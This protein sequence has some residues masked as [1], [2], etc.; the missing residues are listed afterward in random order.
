MIDYKEVIDDKGL[1]FAEPKLKT[2]IPEKLREEILGF[3]LLEWISSIYWEISR[4]IEQASEML[5]FS[6]PSDEKNEWL[7]VYQNKLDHQQR[8]S[9]W[10]LNHNL[11]PRPVKGQG[12]GLIQWRCRFIKDRSLRSIFYK[13]IKDGVCSNRGLHQT[14]D[15]FVATYFPSEVIRGLSD[16]AH[17]LIKTTYKEVFSSRLEEVLNPKLYRPIEMISKFVHGGF[18]SMALDEIMG[19]AI[20]LG[21]EKLSLTRNLEVEFLRLIRCNQKYQI[22]S[23][24][25]FIDGSD[26]YTVGEVKEIDTGKVCAKGKAKFFLLN[27]EVCQRIFPGIYNDPQLAYL[28]R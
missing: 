9:S 7:K 18:I 3:E 14:I 28:Y 11:Y 12:I 20:T 17:D 15:E 13:M 6:S 24:V 10:L 16:S 25:I 26:V 4:D 1:L 21:M 19:Y 8:I 22:E 23:R 27:K 5:K 2:L